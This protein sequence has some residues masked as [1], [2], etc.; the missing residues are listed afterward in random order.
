MDVMKNATVRLGEKTGFFEVD[1]LTTWFHD[2]FKTHKIDVLVAMRRRSEMPMLDCKVN[3]LFVGKEEIV[4]SPD[5]K[6]NAML[7]HNPGLGNLRRL[8]PNIDY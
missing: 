3:P 4:Y 5:Q 8:F 1:A 2:E 7:E 6:Y